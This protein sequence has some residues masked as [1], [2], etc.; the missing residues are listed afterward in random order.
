M[1]MKKQM[2]NKEV[3]A[4]LRD[5]LEWVRWYSAVWNEVFSEARSLIWAHRNKERLN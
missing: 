1:T 5:M 4:E 2:T 3:E